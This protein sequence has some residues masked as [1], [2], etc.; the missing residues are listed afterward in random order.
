M[1]KVLGLSLDKVEDYLNSLVSDIPEEVVNLAE[2]RKEAKANKNW[3]KAD[4]LRGKITELGYNVLDSK[5]GYE[6]KKI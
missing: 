2:K 1:D 3:A 5:D 6:L 4:E